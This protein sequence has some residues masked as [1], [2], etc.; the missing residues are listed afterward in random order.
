MIGRLKALR[1][2]RC[3]RLAKLTR[4]LRASRMLKRWETRVSINYAVLGLCRSLVYYL[5]LAHWSACALVLPTTF[6]GDI[7]ETWVGKF[8]YADSAPIE[9]YVASFYMSLQ[10]RLAFLA[11]STLPINPCYML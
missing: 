6:Y 11:S 8:G 9:I 4:L 3:T 1:V 10:V 2:I 5:M 7:H